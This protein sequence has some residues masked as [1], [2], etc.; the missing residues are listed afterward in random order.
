MSVIVIQRRSKGVIIPAD[1]EIMWYGIAE[2][3][4]TDL[5]EIDSAIT[6]NYV[7]G[8][9][10]SN[11]IPAGG[12][13]HDHTVPD[14]S[15]VAHH[16]HTT[17]AGTSSAAA[18]QTIQQSS[19]VTLAAQSHTHSVSTRTSG[20]EGAHLH[21]TSDTGE[22][23][24]LPP[25][26]ELY[27]IKA[28]VDTVVPV[29]G[30]VMWKGAAAA[31]PHGFQLCNGEGGRPDL[32]EK[33]VYGAAED[34]DVGETRGA[35]THVHS[36]PDADAVGNHNHS[37]SGVPFTGGATNSHGHPYYT[38]YST[39]GSHSHTGAGTL[40]SAGGHSHTIGNTNAGSSLPPYLLLYYLIKSE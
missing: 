3:L 2:E 21:E 30:I 31:R 19:G 28:L 9:T 36:N 24:I 26:I 33:F 17:N 39:V 32:R 18:G 38:E 25:T 13:N 16:T 5:W 15:Q 20:S 7:K 34:A 27:W 14:T 11:N 37:V 10:G 29:G 40:P 35:A 22:E 4:N 1:A 8:G 6:G 23:A 12:G